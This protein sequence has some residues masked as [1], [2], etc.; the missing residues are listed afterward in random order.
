M[1]NRSRLQIFVEILR[2]CETPKL[3]SHIVNQV[4]LNH[5]ILPSFTEPLESQGHLMHVKNKYETTA[6]GKELFQ[7]LIVINEYI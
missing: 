5:S 2:V 4:F 1:A 6:K 7:T 3:K